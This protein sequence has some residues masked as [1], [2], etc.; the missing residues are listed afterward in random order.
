MVTGAT[1]YKKMKASNPAALAKIIVLLK[2]HSDFAKWQAQISEQP[3]ANE[4]GERYLFELA[5]R[6]ADD[7]RQTS[8]DHP[9]CALPHNK[10]YLAE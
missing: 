3:L 2:Q 8:Y 1:A 4:N 9:V 6:W 5:A 7:M 10:R